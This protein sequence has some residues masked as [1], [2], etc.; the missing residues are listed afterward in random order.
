MNK[1][2]QE[3]L[4]LSFGALL[5]FGLFAVLHFRAEKPAEKL[6]WESYAAASLIGTVFGFAVYRAAAAQAA[7]IEDLQKRIAA[8]E[9]SART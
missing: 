6:R 8:L 1:W 5:V 2:L 7:N 3:L 4:L 9:N